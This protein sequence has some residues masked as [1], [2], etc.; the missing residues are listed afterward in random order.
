M[1]ANSDSC[2]LDYFVV[3]CM[4]LPLH[5]SCQ[6]VSQ[7]SASRPLKAFTIGIFVEDFGSPPTIVSPILEGGG[8]GGGVLV[9]CSILLNNQI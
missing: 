2:K 4:K 1:A 9:T 8:G 6:P 3:L 5:S 7:S